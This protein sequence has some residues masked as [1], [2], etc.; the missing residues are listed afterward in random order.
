MSVWNVTGID[1]II[2][3]VAWCRPVR[4]RTLRVLDRAI[5]GKYRFRVPDRVVAVEPDGV[6]GVV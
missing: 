3:F 5:D 2:K 1:N 6:D 4:A